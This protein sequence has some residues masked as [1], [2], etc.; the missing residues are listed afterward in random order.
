[1]TTLQDIEHA[2]GELSPSELEELY[3]WFDDRYARQIDERLKAELDAGRF[4]ERINRAI[5][6]HKRGRT[7]PL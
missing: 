5:A 1:M 6:D 4:D 7:R 3:T 2:I